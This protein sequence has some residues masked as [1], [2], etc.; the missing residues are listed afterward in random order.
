MIRSFLS[1]LIRQAGSSGKRAGLYLRAAVSLAII[2]A[3]VWWFS[4][5]AL[6]TAILAVEPST[7]ILVIANIY[8]GIHT[9]LTVNV[10]GQAVQ[11]LEVVTQ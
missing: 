9:E 4:G 7:W 6:L 3:L 8:F 5:D 1:G 2:A 10:A 11:M